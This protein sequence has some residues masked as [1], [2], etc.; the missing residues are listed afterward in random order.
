MTNRMYFT[1]SCTR[2]DLCAVHRYAMYDL[3]SRFSNVPLWERDEI[4]EK[5]LDEPFDQQKWANAKRAAK[6]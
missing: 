6:H 4:L 5:W 2:E 1:L 3:A